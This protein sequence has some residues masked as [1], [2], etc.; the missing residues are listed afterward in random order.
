M[1]AKRDPVL[2][3]AFELAGIKIDPAKAGTLFPVEWK[4]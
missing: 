1:A 3:R 4:K 2:A